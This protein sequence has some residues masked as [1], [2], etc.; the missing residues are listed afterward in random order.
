[1]E[2]SLEDGLVGGPLAGDGAWNFFDLVAQTVKGGVTLDSLLEQVVVCADGITFR[3]LQ[4][5]NGVQH[6][7][8]LAPH[9]SAIGISAGHPIDRTSGLV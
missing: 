6:L 2:R 4:K 3:F 9:A 7:L 5:Q 1:L 8:H